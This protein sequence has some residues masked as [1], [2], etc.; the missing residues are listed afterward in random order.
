[1]ILD[2]GMVNVKF[3][4]LLGGAPLRPPGA[5]PRKTTMP[6]TMPATTMTEVAMMTALRFILDKTP[7]PVRFVWSF[8]GPARVC[9]RHIALG[10]L[11]Q[12]Y[13]RG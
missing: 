8:V 4:A 7:K 11:A 13:P 2:A 6:E 1:M 12:S 5:D 9:G 3:H 10:A